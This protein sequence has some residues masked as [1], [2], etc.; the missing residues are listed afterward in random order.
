MKHTLTLAIAMIV[1]FAAAAQAATDPV[2]GYWLTANNKAIV[3]FVPC[4]SQTCGRMVWVAN[5]H[6]ESGR[7][8]RDAHNSDIAKRDRPI[9]GL[10]L[11]GGMKPVGQGAWD[12]GWIYNPRDGGTYSATI[13]AVSDS[14][15]KV[16]GYVGLQ[17]LGKSQIW[18]RVGGDRGGC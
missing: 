16:H 5:P 18:T 7:V 6:D 17:L 14:R 10:Q 9:C 2:H 8:K 11:V 12:G 3:E 4:G 1:G 15:L 13:E